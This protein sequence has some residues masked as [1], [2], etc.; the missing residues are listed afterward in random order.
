MD[1]LLGS[2]YSH[3]HNESYHLKIYAPRNEA[4][5]S[6]RPLIW[7]ASDKSLSIQTHI[8]KLNTCLLFCDYFN[9]D[10][11]FLLYLFH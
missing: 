6:G 2:P 5:I 10:N 9:N 8:V 1:V 4:A 7:I 3:Y 11:S